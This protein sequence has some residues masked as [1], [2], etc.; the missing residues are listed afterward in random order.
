MKHRRSVLILN[1]QIS[2]GGL[3]AGYY[4][5]GLGEHPHRLKSP[6]RERVVECG[7][8]ATEVAPS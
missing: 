7:Y 8:G 3:K 1:L 4:M 5:G 6:E 2:G